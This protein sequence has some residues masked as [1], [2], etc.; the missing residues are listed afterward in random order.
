LNKDQ[1][2]AAAAAA[3]AIA[4]LQGGVSELKRGLAKAR[5]VIL[6]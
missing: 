3:T 6:I 4:H 2:A 1:L 5:M